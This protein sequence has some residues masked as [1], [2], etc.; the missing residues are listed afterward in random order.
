MPTARGAAAGAPRGAA[1]LA[2]GGA[3]LRKHQFG[4]GPRPT[5]RGQVDALPLFGQR[6]QTKG[7]LARPRLRPAPERPAGLRLTQTARWPLPRGDVPG[8]QF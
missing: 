1:A 6:V 8:K 4:D 7:R 3:A 5:K 2:R